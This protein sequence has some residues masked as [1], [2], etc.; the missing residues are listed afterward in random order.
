YVAREEQRLEAYRRLAAVTTDAEVDDIRDEW[1]DR[2][3]PVPSPGEALLGVA[4]LRAE[5]VRAGVREVTVAR[6][7]A[8]LSPLTLPASRRIRLQRLRRDAIVTD[9]LAQ[10]IVRVAA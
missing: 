4:R 7:V 9:D 6:G 5:C 1:V 10:L 8:R 2:Y 3:G